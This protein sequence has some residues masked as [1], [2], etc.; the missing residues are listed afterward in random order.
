[1]LGAWLTVLSQASEELSAFKPGDA[2]TLF[3]TA[4]GKVA[5]ATKPESGVRSTLV[6]VV[7]SVSD[8]TATV[9]PVADWTDAS[10]SAVSFKGTVSASAEKLEGELVI[11]SSSRSGY[12]T[13]TA[14]PASTTAGAIN[15]PLRTLGG[16]ILSDRV[17]LYERTQGA[18]PKRISWSQITVD[19]IPAS[20]ISY[21]GTDLS[22]AIDIIILNDVTGDGY[23]YGYMS[24][25][26]EEVTVPGLTQADGTPGPSSTYNLYYTVVENSSGKHELQTLSSAQIRTAPGGMAAAANGRVGTTVTLTALSGVPR[27]AFNMTDMTVTVNGVT[28]PIAQNVECHNKAAGSW[29]GNGAEGLNAARAYADTLTIYYDKAPSQGGKIRLVVVG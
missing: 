12:L 1:M 16:Q 27:S 11:L 10:G 6:G 2:V 23:T 26:T 20:K 17:A 29:F 21:V 22:G 8:G 9:Q 14:V 24:T 4:D 28:Y 19:T 5:G 15:V 3:L 13:L 25:R 7:T 18:A